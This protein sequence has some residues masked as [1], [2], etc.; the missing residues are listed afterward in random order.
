[1]IYLTTD[2]ILARISQTDLDYLT[3]ASEGPLN[4][5]ELDAIDEIGSYL[6]SRY[7]TA[8]IFAPDQAEEDKKPIIKRML[9]DIVL[10]NLHLS[11]NPRNIPEFRVQR[12]DDAIKWLKAV[13]DPRSNVSA[14]G[15]LPRR[16][17]GEKRGND[18]TWGSREKRKNDY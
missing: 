11:A 6:N 12:R 9:T 1:M 5:S 18:I 4:E 8:A 7:D 10:Y 16:D 15:I 17:F 13:A 2:A 3:D 14:D